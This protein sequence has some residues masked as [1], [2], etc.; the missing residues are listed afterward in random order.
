[1][2]KI[3]QIL[4]NDFQTY[5]TGAN[6]DV[7]LNN[8]YV[9]EMVMIGWNAVVNSSPLYS[10]NKELFNDIADGV[11]RV[12]GRFVINYKMTG[13]L[14]YIIAKG[15]KMINNPTGSNISP[16][17]FGNYSNNIEAGADQQRYG[18]NQYGD[19]EFDRNRTLL[20]RVIF[21]RNTAGLSNSEIDN[22]KRQMKEYIWQGKNSADGINNELAPDHL[23]NILRKRY[24][25]MLIIYGNPNSPEHTIHNI[26][27]MK[28]L[29]VE[30]QV[31]NDGTP[32]QEVYTFIARDIDQP[33]LNLRNEQG[34]AETG[35]RQF[36]PSARQFL[37]YLG[38][39]MSK[40]MKQAVIDPWL[41]ISKLT[42]LT[43][44]P[45]SALAPADMAEAPIPIGYMG[46]A[47]TNLL[48]NVSFL[49]N[50]TDDI[51]FYL[52]IFMTN[53]RPYM[54]DL[55]GPINPPDV[56]TVQY[57]ETGL[58]GIIYKPGSDFQRTI[59]PTP[60]VTKNNQTKIY[61]G[62]TITELER[63]ELLAN[64]IA[65]ELETDIKAIRP[66]EDYDFFSVS[67][68]MSPVITS[69]PSGE[70]ITYFFKDMISGEYQLE[71]TY[72]LSGDQKVFTTTV[73][74]FVKP[75]PD[76][77]SIIT[78]IKEMSGAVPDGIEASGD[79]SFHIKFA[80]ML[81]PDSIPS[82]YRGLPNV[83]LLV[84]NAQSDTH[85][86]DNFTGLNNVIDWGYTCTNID[87]FMH[88]PDI[89]E[90]ST[91][92]QTFKS[93]SSYVFGSFATNRPSLLEVNELMALPE[94]A[95][96]IDIANSFGFAS[97]YP[98]ISWTAGALTSSFEYPGHR[99][100]YTVKNPNK[101]LNRQQQPEYYY[102]SITVYESSNASV[103]PTKTIP[104]WDIVGDTIYI[105]N[106]EALDAGSA[107]LGNVDHT[108]LYERLVLQEEERKVRESLGLPLPSDLLL[109][110]HNTTTGS[111][112]VTLCSKM[113]SSNFP[114]GDQ[115]IELVSAN[116]DFPDTR[117]RG[118]YAE[119]IQALAVFETEV[120]A[121]IRALRDALLA[122]G[123][124][125]GISA[126]EPGI[127]FFTATA[128]VDTRNNSN[129]AAQ[130]TL[131]DIR[132]KAFK[133]LIR[134][135]YPDILAFITFTGTNMI[136]GI[137]PEATDTICDEWFN[138]GIVLTASDDFLAVIQT[139]ANTNTPIESIKITTPS[140]VISTAGQFGVFLDPDL[141]S[142]KEVQYNDLVKLL[143]TLFG[144][145]AN[146]ILENTDLSNTPYKIS[147]KQAL[148]PGLTSVKAAFRLK[149]TMVPY[150]MPKLDPN[151]T[152]YKS[153]NVLIGRDDTYISALYKLLSV[154]NGI[155][156][157]TKDEDTF[158]Y[159]MVTRVPLSDKFIPYRAFENLISIPYFGNTDFATGD[160]STIGRF[161]SAE[162]R[163]DG[164]IYLRHTNSSLELM[165]KSLV[166]YAL[167]LYDLHNVP[168]NEQVNTYPFI[169]R[170]QY[171]L[172]KTHAKNEQIAYYPLLAIRADQL[173]PTGAKPIN[174]D[175]DLIVLMAESF[176]G[177]KIQYFRDAQWKDYTGNVDG[178]RGL[179]IRIKD[180]L[181]YIIT[182]N[183]PLD[184]FN[185]TDEL[186]YPE[187]IRIGYTYI[188]GSGSY[189]YGT[190]SRNIGLDTALHTYHLR[191]YSDIYKANGDGIRSYLPPMSLIETEKNR[192][193]PVLNRAS[194]RFIR[195]CDIDLNP[196]PTRKA[197]YTTVCNL[198]NGTL[199]SSSNILTT[200]LDT[201]PNITLMSDKL[202]PLKGYLQKE[203]N[204]TIGYNGDASA[205]IVIVKMDD[206]FDE[207]AAVNKVVFN[208][209]RVAASTTGTQ[210]SG[211]VLALTPEEK[212]RL[213]A[214]S[215]RPS[216]LTKIDL[217]KTVSLLRLG[218]DP[219]KYPEAKYPQELSSLN[220]SDEEIALAL[221]D[222]LIAANS[223]EQANLP[224]L[225]FT[226]A[227]SGKEKGDAASVPRGVTLSSV[228]SPIQA[229]KVTDLIIEGM[230]AED[231]GLFQRCIKS[232]KTTIN[233]K[234]AE[235]FPSDT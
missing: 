128:T 91:L 124:R 189:A 192:I 45:I 168:L 129:L 81:D 146:S 20:D 133:E 67:G 106:E 203:L 4:T 25:D 13:Y 11:F 138:R 136:Q 33:M 24:F 120:V 121:P 113:V 114:G 41:G 179:F 73:E 145:A 201:G 191:L 32:I 202:A 84:A 218:S 58:D 187:K 183:G 78:L 37:D 23:R 75:V 111:A 213:E 21:D 151:T 19:V 163:N 95:S 87:L 6:V 7:F 227:V 198:N 195:I 15:D 144:P 110:M 14:E 171:T 109:S 88:L 178:T 71:N 211:L 44:R 108:V 69:A 18:I 27:D 54:V 159:E 220:S 115:I 185:M 156:H 64:L 42:P 56:I 130:K 205:Y 99:Y 229:L 173:L 137:Q 148:A 70:T 3:E 167:R 1:M 16:M 43:V 34:F 153:A 172:G 50:T 140:K 39:L 206:T 77:T 122:F 104:I 89:D 143:I 29:N 93:V 226:T 235:I 200:Y 147:W 118:V 53:D 150:L 188:Q 199:Y 22:V 59:Y 216:M 10:Y 196:D 134:I 126:L 103:I 94:G 219:D 79:M 142:K 223:K 61:H 52:G 85:H 149:L 132:I 157:I 62:N 182:I 225:H 80:D 217:I 63:N 119:F 232:A 12:E 165:Q 117:Y 102:D 8:I 204:N 131:A 2:K 30:T 176:T 135:K 222:Y 170:Y 190:H 166:K 127:R 208:T 212:T 49:P 125:Y 194:D 186:S 221:K 76:R 83:A 28:I 26:V 97:P 72:M 215:F 46:T 210:N 230:F 5:Y 66:F 141:I 101:T 228:S 96:D 31:A 160:I 38:Q 162:D 197:R 214:L 234:L 207:G 193:S 152:M 107:A 68:N 92:E 47:A 112:T 177:V 74:E 155:Y 65:S 123:S 116:K 51:P 100:A 164:C 169:G 57:E 55:P 60:Y 181:F 161:A 105:L 35:G 158:I 90:L 17:A 36:I 40:Y 154:N 174:P 98:V 9:D 180:D 224:Y 86:I 231:E 82:Q 175:E 184:I 48:A 139:I 233:A 209:L